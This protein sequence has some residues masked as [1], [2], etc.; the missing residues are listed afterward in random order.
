MADTSSSR[1]DSG[2]Y[3]YGQSLAHW[4][5]GSLGKT[6]KNLSSPDIRLPNA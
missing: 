3:I 4:R 5:F 2:L 6:L 1:R